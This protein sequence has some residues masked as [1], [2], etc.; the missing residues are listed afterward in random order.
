MITDQAHALSQ[1]N[2][3]QQERLRYI[4]LRL[5]FLGVIQRP[6]LI[7]RFGIQSAAASRD[8]ALYKAIA[9]DNIEYDR[10]TKR[11]VC[12]K[13]FRPLF[14]VDVDH[15]LIW[16][17]NQ[18]GSTIAD[19]NAPA[20]TCI[21]PAR[22]T[23][24]LLAILPIITRAIHG[25]QVLEIEYH[26]ITSGKSKRV[27]IPFALIDTGLHWLIRAFDRKTSEFRDFVLTRISRV[28]ALSSAVIAQHEASEFDIQWNRVVEL[29]LVPHPSHPRPDITEMDFGMVE[30][31]LRIRL[32]AAVAGYMLRRWSV[33]CSP[34]HS[35]RG[36]EYQLWLKDNLILYGVKNALIAPGYVQSDTN[37]GSSV[38]DEV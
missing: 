36:S 7:N 19:S 16:L 21:T 1:L 13:H 29:D 6:D 38:G 2:Q 23:Q 12:G 31:H 37:D 26:A 20:L 30:N 14:A 8:V 5:R 27:I 4:E 22:L 15:V 24:P 35:L 11:Y 10:S 3:S 33:D 17:A 9:P 25:N 18:T 28:K 32:R 34:D